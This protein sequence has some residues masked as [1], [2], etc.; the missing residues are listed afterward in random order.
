[1]VSFVGKIFK[2]DENNEKHKFGKVWNYGYYGDS[3]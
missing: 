1:M 2:G 3:T